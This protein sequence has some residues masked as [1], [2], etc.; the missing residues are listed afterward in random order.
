MFRSF[1]GV[2]PGPQVVATRGGGWGEPPNKIYLPR[3]HRDTLQV[4]GSDHAEGRQAEALGPLPQVQVAGEIA[5]GREP[6][7]DR[8]RPATATVISA[9]CRACT[10]PTAGLAGPDRG[11]TGTDHPAYLSEKISSTPVNHNDPASRRVAALRPDGTDEVVRFVAGAARQAAAACP[12]ELARGWTVQPPARPP[13]LDPDPRPHPA[14]DAYGEG[15]LMYS[16]PPCW[17]G[18]PP[19]R[20]KGPV[21]SGSAMG[22]VSEH[23]ALDVVTTRAR[24]V[25][26]FGVFDLPSIVVWRTSW[27]GRVRRPSRLRWRGCW[28][29]P[30]RSG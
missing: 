3:A 5:L 23:G 17:M 6:Q 27:S 28:P 9:T 18:G 30:L 1:C 10:V 4:P 13:P 8:E 11:Q 19:L 24:I 29:R 12:Q 22:I 25:C 2:L 26:G 20:P 7:P 16:P 14:P 21:P 15:L